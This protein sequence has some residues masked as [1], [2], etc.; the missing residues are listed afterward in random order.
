VEG[1]FNHLSAAN[2][3]TG[4][5]CGF[6]LEH[7]RYIVID[8]VD[9]ILEQPQLIDRIQQIFKAAAVSPPSPE[10]V[11]VTSS[12][13]VDTPHH[14]TVETHT[15]RKW[16]ANRRLLTEPPVCISQVLLFVVCCAH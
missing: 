1:V 10:S 6:T 5:G 14:H 8:E 12:S 16:T 15:Y 2:N 13:H 9:R 3:N 11:D 4:G 7:L